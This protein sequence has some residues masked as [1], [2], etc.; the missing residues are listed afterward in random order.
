MF[1][2]LL[3]LFNY[4]ADGYFSAF[5]ILLS[6]VFCSPKGKAVCS[7]DYLCTHMRNNS[8]YIGLQFCINISLYSPKVTKKFVFCV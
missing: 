2:Y 7:H 4:P 1:V 8:L 3:E 6:C 5:Y